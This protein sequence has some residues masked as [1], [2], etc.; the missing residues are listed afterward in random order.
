MFRSERERSASARE[1]L[2]LLS[3]RRLSRFSAPAVFHYQNCLLILDRNLECTLLGLT[4]FNASDNTSLQALIFPLLSRNEDWVGA[5]DPD[6]KADHQLT[7][8]QLT[9]VREIGKVH[10]CCSITLSLLH[11]SRLIVHG[12]ISAAV[13]PGAV[14]PTVNSCE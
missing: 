9:D 12:V 11:V 14:R 8:E 4:F 6:W 7:W 2:V 1:T 3:T 13:C 10:Y 5:E